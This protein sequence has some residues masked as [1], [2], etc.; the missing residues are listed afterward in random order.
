VSDGR[1]IMVYWLCV[2]EKIRR[3]SEQRV[4]VAALLSN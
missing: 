4:P 1:N 3:L 2:L